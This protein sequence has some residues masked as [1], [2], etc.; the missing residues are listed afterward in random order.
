MADQFLAGLLPLSLR[1]LPLRRLLPVHGGA[2][3]PIE[4]P[5][6]RQT[7]SFLRRR[8]SSPQQARWPPLGALPDR[9]SGSLWSQFGD[10]VLPDAGGDVVQCV[11]EAV[12]GVGVDEECGGGEGGGGQV[13]RGVEEGEG[14]GQLFSFYFFILFIKII[15]EL[16]RE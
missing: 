2:L 6:R 4:A 5:L 13:G 1:P 9:R 3:P 11:D 16:I 15:R 10:R 12:A 8:G 7:P 14:A